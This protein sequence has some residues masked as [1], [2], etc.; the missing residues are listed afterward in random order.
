MKIR[1]RA[2]QFEKSRNRR[3]CR[4]SSQ[5]ESRQRKLR[6]LDLFV[7]EHGLP[8]RRAAGHWLRVLSL[9][10]VLGGDRY[11]DR[12]T[13]IHFSVREV[14]DAIDGSPKVVRAVAR[15]RMIKP[16]RLPGK[17][18]RKLFFKKVAIRR[19]V[20][21]YRL[22]R[23]SCSW[24][25]PPKQYSRVFRSEKIALN[26]DLVRG[27]AVTIEEAMTQLRISRQGVQYYLKRGVKRG[28]LKKIPCGYRTVLIERKS[29]ARLCQRRLAKHAREFEAAKKMLE[30]IRGCRIEIEFV[31]PED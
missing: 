12:D 3:D 17:K 25:D 21:G 10:D 19:F 30:R 28:G 4:K 20:N 6:R 13:P 5:E 18:A 15:K 14:A 24:D 23:L 1:N 29:L 8:N 16:Y 31:E 9:R 27:D 26:P 2:G 11:L 22:P 7:R